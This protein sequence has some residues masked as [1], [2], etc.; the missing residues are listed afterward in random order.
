VEISIR[1]TPIF[2][3]TLDINSRSLHGN[4]ADAFADMP[5]I[6]P[7][8][9]R[10]SIWP[11]LPRNKVIFNALVQ[12]PHKV[13]AKANFRD[14]GS[15]T[16]SRSKGEKKIMNRLLRYLV[17]GVILMGTRIAG[18]GQGKFYIVG[19]GTAPDL[20]TLRGVEAIREASIIL[21]EQPSEK[22]YWKDFIGDKEVWYC[23]H[24]ARVGLGLDPKGIK[25]PDIRAI[26]EKNAGAR[27]EAVDKIRKAIE[28]GKTVAALEGGD[29]MIY[30][31]TFY[32]EMLPKNLPSEIIPGIGAFQAS[33]AAVKMSPVF[34]YDTNS[35]IITMDDWP[36]RSDLNKKLM[37]TRTSMIFYSM[38]LN[39]PRLF[40]QLKQHYPAATPVAVVS[41]AGD[42]QKQKVLRSTV[43]RFLTEV[44]YKNLPVDAH[45]VLVGKF[46]EVGQARSDALMG[47]RRA[48]ER[49]HGGTPTAK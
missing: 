20:I 1:S 31:T 38:N 11:A 27:H 21:L 41:F 37:A 26:V 23:P 7:V 17:F 46:L 15:L 35:A 14:E 16:L 6:S 4:I 28:E 9:T 24:G 32:L 12:L 8:N 36:G 10:I 39:Y 18:G 49:V 19:M 13:L 30:G 25:D 42:R 22:E 34:G 47:T 5:N 44:D 48:I 3:L 33:T 2:R 45:M 29:A 40:A 43:N